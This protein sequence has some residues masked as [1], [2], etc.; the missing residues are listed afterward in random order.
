MN[1][2][3]LKVDESSL[4][5]A[6]ELLNDDMLVAFPTETVYGLGANAYSSEAIREVYRAKGRPL[7]NPLIVH[8]PKDYDVNEIVYDSPLAKRVR[9]AFLPGPLTIVYNGKNVLSPLVSCG[10]ETLALRC[11]SLE[12]SQQFLSFVNVP[13]AAPSANVSKHTSPVTAQH[14]FEDFDG[15][16][17]L[18]LDGGRSQ[19]GIESTV[20]DL[21]TDTPVILRK[22]LVSASDIKK[23]VGKCVY[24]EENSE[25]NKRSPGTKYRHYTPKVETAFF[26]NSELN[27]ALNLYEQAVKSGR[28][29]YV[30]CDG[31]VAEKLGGYNVF[32]LGKSGESMASRLY[33]YLHES[34]IACDLLIGISL[35]VCDELVLSVNNRYLKAFA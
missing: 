14:V 1:T 19:G 30:M 16:I 34:E 22:G 18:I 29:P 31:F 35:N 24:A 5:K 20:L 23:V 9:E 13:V 26:D 33:Y 32:D 8:V 3:I 17:P 21:T 15:K 25:L 2:E 4:K 27:K 6:K 11:P 10:L 7:D 28:K 12:A